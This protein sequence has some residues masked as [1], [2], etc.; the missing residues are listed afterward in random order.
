MIVINSLNKKIERL[1]KES[2]ISK[3]ILKY[4]NDYSSHKINLYK[5]EDKYPIL[6]HEQFYTNSNKENNF[7]N[8]KKT[9]FH[10]K[11]R[12]NSKNN[13]YSSNNQPTGE[14]SGHS[15]Y[16]KTYA[17]TIENRLYSNNN[18]KGKIQRKPLS[19]KQNRIKKNT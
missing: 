9:S 18:S 19:S 7:I 8:Y 2:S 4:K 6:I 5:S 12:N 14:N 16:V 3:N 1:Q 17:Q 15:F 10:V 13:N 11:W